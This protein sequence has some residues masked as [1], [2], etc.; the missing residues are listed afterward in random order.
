MWINYQQLQ[1]F[2]EI[3]RKGS[4][5]AAA[6][7]L[8]ISSPALSMQLKSLEDVLGNKLFLRQKRK[9][10][11]TDFGEYVLEYAEKIFSTGEELISNINSN[12]MKTRVSIGVNSGLPKTMTNKLIQHILANHK[13][14]NI[15]ITEGDDKKLIKDLIARDCDLIL[16]NIPL[17]DADNSISSHYAYESNLSFYGTEKFEYIREGFPKSLDNAPLIHPSLHSNL[18]HIIDQWYLKH[19]VHYENVIEIHDSASKKILARE[20]YGIVVLAQIGAR[21]LLQNNAIIH[22][23]DMQVSEKFY[24]TTRKNELVTKNEIADIVENFSSIMDAESL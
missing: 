8:R 20:G 17:N 15:R 9:L 19:Q 10:I 13:N 23:G 12:T 3:A 22:L 1:Y 4:I 18:R 24:C 16:S 2:R 6:E 7:S 21:S 11:I 14:T 5:K